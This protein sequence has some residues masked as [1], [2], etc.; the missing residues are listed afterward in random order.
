MLRL[1][2]D[3]FIIGEATSSHFFRVTTSTQQLLFG[4]SYFFRAA[5]FF[6]ELLFQKSHLFAAVIFF[7]NNYF[8]RVK[9]LSS[10]HFLRM[11]NPLGL[12]F[13]GTATFLAKDLFTI[14]ISIEELLFRRG[15]FCTESIFSEEQHENRKTPVFQ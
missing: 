11:G 9:L 2:Q 15:Y 13:F 5:A 4:S 1:F 14:K 6:E 10:S 8:F 12:L 3:S 7:Q